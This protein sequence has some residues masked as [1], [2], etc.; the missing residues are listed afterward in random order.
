M[1]KISLSVLTLLI[2][3]SFSV[4]SAGF[5]CSLAK[6]KVEKMI[7]ND[8]ELSELDSQL[9]DVFL[10]AQ[11]ETAGFDGDTGE[12]LDPV[13]KE[14]SKWLLTVRN[15][16]SNTSC[17]KTAYRTHIKQIQKLMN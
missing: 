13:G 11:S 16:C 1:T 17:L 2:S 15:K 6:T 5:D 9:K 14:N 10:A 3:T 7:C 4:Q 8:T 12:R